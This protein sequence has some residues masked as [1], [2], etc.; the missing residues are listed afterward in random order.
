MKNQNKTQMVSTDTLIR[1]VKA[2]ALN[3]NLIAYIEDNPSQ[4]FGLTINGSPTPKGWLA[5]NYFV[6]RGMAM[7]EALLLVIQFGNIMKAC[8]GDDSKFVLGQRIF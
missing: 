3:K 5:V 4:L 1:F 8:F 7:D 6:R 2:Q